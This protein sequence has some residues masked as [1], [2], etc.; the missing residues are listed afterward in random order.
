MMLCRT[1]VNNFIY[2][3]F[4]SSYTANFNW[5]RRRADNS[6]AGRR[7][8]RRQGLLKLGGGGVAGAAGVGLDLS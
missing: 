7:R 2:L 3:D 4:H 1:V 5:S 6:P 8:R